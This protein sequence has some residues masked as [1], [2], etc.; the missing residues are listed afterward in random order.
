MRPGVGFG[1]SGES[2]GMIE[3][4]ARVHPQ[5][6][7]LTAE[8]HAR[9][10]TP[11]TAPGRALML[12]FMPEGG[13]AER[14]HGRDLAHLTALIDRHGGAH[15]PPGANHHFAELGRF[16]LKWERHT[17][18]V[19]YTLYEEGPAE[20]LF[21]DGLVRQLP[22]T[23]L[24]E[25][26]GS[27]FAAVQVELVDAG[28][29]DA[30][31]EVLDG[32]L[33]RHLVGESMAAAEVLDGQAIAAGDFRIHESGF[34]R[35][36]LVLQ[37]PVGPQR[38]GRVVQRLLEIENYRGLAMM[39]LPL[40]RQLSAR[41]TAI[42][43]ELSDLIQ[44]VADEREQP[45]EADILRQL[46]ALSAEIEALNASS[47]FRFGASQAYEAIVNERIRMLRETRLSGRQLFAEFM[48]RRFD[49]AMRTCRSTSGR[50]HE[51]ATRAARAA[52]LLRT[53]VNV[54]V[55][56]QNQQLLQSMNRRAE[57]Q[58]RL[59]ETVEGLSVVAISY[60]AVGLAG[61]LLAPLAARAGL[62]KTALTALVAL[63]IIAGV[64]WFVRRIRARIGSRET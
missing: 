49:P 57:L 42:D 30:A 40:A 25:A 4:H 54:A 37:A 44:Q 15:P 17:E 41:I 3:R 46:T 12:A 60:Y 23:W 45:A 43:R 27:L 5:R 29:R 55:E 9:P 53:R 31:L 8:L 51:L 28:D 35:F 58:L 63:P 16:R 26:P 6:Y 1:G 33:R 36:A 11:M 39:A 22:E 50:L 21:E 59:Q 34:T 52:D 18:F 47:A 62:D 2:A 13:A 38:Q 24:A 19:S 10:F 7:A 64:W 32:P 56:A 61:I 48:L 14:D 20:R